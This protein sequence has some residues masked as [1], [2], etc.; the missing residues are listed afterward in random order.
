MRCWFGWHKWHYT[1]RF[2]K[3]AHHPDEAVERCCASCRLRQYRMP[4]YSLLHRAASP[5]GCS[6]LVFRT[7]PGRG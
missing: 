5:A 2:G 7:S 4:H 3:P 1:D 6:W